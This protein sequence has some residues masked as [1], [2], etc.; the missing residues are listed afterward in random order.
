MKQFFRNNGL[1]LV[2]I[3]LFLV[4]LTGQLITGY[5]EHVTKESNFL[6]E[7]NHT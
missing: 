1:S 3:S 2:F 5:H 4:S 7:N 6:K